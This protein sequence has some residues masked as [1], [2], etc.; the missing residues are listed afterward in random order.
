MKPL[1][2]A[3]K[4]H[5]EQE[6]TSL[7][8][9]WK[10]TRRDGE[11]FAFTDHDLDL[12][13][14]GDLYL[15][16]EGYDRS[17]LKGSAGLDTDHMTLLGLLS[18]EAL[19]ERDLRA[20][21]FDF[22][23]IRFFLVNWQD[24]SQ[25]V[26]PLRLG[27]LGEVTW[28]DDHFEAELRGL[29]NAFKTHIGAVYTPECQADLGD[30]ECGIDLTAHQITDEVVSVRGSR[31]FTLLDCEKEDAELAGGVVQFL[32]G[33]NEALRLEILSWDKSKKEITLFL[34]PPF[35]VSSG[36][37]VT[38]FEGCDKRLATCRDRFSNIVNFRGFPFIPG[39]DSLQEGQN[40]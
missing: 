7:C 12:V 1:S 15:A 5:L 22:A 3:L 34:P 30:D 26:L 31:I 33:E 2:T 38:L 20:G 23:E 21:L 13:V 28:R 27:W 36:D 25:G 39:T 11:I 24:L 4:S 29:S 18:D 9:C 19:S 14:E 32:D 35:A 10:I 37:Q 8:S 40:A 6:V 17:A 16:S